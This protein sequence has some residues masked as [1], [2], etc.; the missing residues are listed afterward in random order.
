MTHIMRKHLYILLLSAAITLAGSCKDDNNDPQEPQ[1]LTFNINGGN[2]INQIGVYATEES[3]FS[4]VRY[5]DNARFS[6][7]NNIFTS[8]DPGTVLSDNGLM[9][10]AY[11]PYT[12]NILP[13]GSDIAQVKTAIDQSNIG[14][15]LNSDFMAGTAVIAPDSKSPVSMTVNRLFAKVNLILKPI[16]SATDLSDAVVRLTLNSIADVNFT[17][18]N[19]ESSSTPAQIIPRG[20]FSVNEE[21]DWT[22]VSVITVPQDIQGNNEFISLT[23]GGN[24]RNYSLGQDLSIVSGQEYDLEV[25]ISRTAEDIIVSIEVTESPWASGLNLDF[26]IN[27]ETEDIDSVSDYDGNRYEVIKA[28]PQLWMASNLRTTHYNDG[29]PINHVPDAD[30]WAIVEN[31]GAYTFYNENE[32]MSERYGLLYNWYTVKTEKLCPEG[33]HVPTM[34]EYEM[35]FDFAG[36]IDFAGEAMKSTSGWRNYRNEELPE[37]QGSNSSGFNGMPGGVRYADGSFSNEGR[38]GYWWT[39][40]A[41]SD[42]ESFG[43]YLYYGGAAASS[44][45]ENNRLGYS[46][47]CIKYQE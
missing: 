20:T 46:V 12:Q 17:T 2:D 44:I 40:S 23:I 13:A 6:K 39:S 27:E 8:T 24:N 36:G 33:W 30:Q 10:T 22:G 16:G 29:A 9:V 4:G 26:N 43:V 14:E 18:S 34:A 15:Y 42:F 21:G 35:L 7:N 32:S 37:I 1:A 19:V 45:T 28:G 47:R 3:T 31:E 41:E 5:L 11:H 38:Y 25:S